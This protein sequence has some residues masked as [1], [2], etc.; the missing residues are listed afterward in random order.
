[1]YQ[2]RLPGGGDEEVKVRKGPW[3]KGSGV[4]WG[5]EDEVEIRGM[6]SCYGEAT[7]KAALSVGLGCT[8]PRS[9]QALL[10]PWQ[11]HTR[12]LKTR[13]LHK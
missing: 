9:T 8:G 10:S 4:S 1:M 2:G 12:L 13:S 7:L 3:W 6:V 5:C 11:R